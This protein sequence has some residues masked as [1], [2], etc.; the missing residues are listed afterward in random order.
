MNSFAVISTAGSSQMGFGHL[1]RSIWLSR[2]LKDE[3]KLDTLFLVS[4]NTRAETILKECGLQFVMVDSP[5]N[6]KEILANT[7]AQ[8][9]FVDKRD[10]KNGF[11]QNPYSF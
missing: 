6:E 2:F 9:L 11:Y 4:K 8:I 7:H 5:E 1:K 10:T 3:Y